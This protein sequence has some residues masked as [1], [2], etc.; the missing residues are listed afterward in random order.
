MGSQ[1]GFIQQ[2]CLQPG[3]R[4][5]SEP[6][7]TQPQRGRRCKRA[8]HVT[9]RRKHSLT[10]AASLLPASLFEISKLKSMPQWL[11][12]TVAQ[13]SHFPEASPWPRMLH[14]T[15]LSKRQTPLK[16]GCLQRKG[17]IS[18]FLHTSCHV[19]SRHSGFPS[20][21]R[22]SKQEDQAWKVLSA[23]VPSHHHA[24]WGHTG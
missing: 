13:S 8:I 19:L 1:P 17:S 10:L 2:I 12:N 14:G 5:D 7:C 4:M 6:Q 18:S 16:P 23:L 9:G 3:Q 21:G 22:N 11:L 15:G 24:S 20:L